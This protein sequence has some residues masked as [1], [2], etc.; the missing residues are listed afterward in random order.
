MYMKSGKMMPPVHA[1]ERVC[2]CMCERHAY[3][4]TCL[5]MRGACVRMPGKPPAQARAMAA[6]LATPTANAAPADGNGTPTSTSALAVIE[7]ARPG[8]TA[9]SGVCCPSRTCCKLPSP[10]KS[11]WG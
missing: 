2:V 6:S 3:A 5:L 10:Q 1:F 7:S 8:H 4:C 9:E 11:V